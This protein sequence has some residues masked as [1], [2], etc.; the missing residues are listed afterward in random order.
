VFLQ[1]MWGNVAWNTWPEFRDDPVQRVHSGPASMDDFAEGLAALVQH[2]VQRRHYT[3]IRWL[4]IS[5]EPGYDWSWWQQP[6]N[7]SMPL[8]AG[9]AAVRQ[10]L[11]RRGITLPLSG[12]DQTDLPELKPSEI[13]YD[14]FI[15]A[16]DLHSYFARFDWQATNGYPLALAEQR[17][18]AWT[19]WAHAR[20]KPM[21]LSEL[22]SMSFGWNGNHP[23]PSTFEAALKDAELV[24]RG[25]NVGVDG[26]NRWSFINRG[27]LD[28]HWEMIQTWDEG[29]QKL[30]QK[31]TPKPNAY[32]VYGLISRLTPKHS[33]I[34][35]CQRMGGQIDGMNRV[36]AAAL[37]SPHGRL[38]WMILNDAPRAWTAHL[39]IKGMPDRVL[40]RYCVSSADRDT[41]TLRIEPIGQL[42]LRRAD[43]QV[44]TTLPP[45][46]L[47]IFS[48]FKLNHS[49][50]GIT[51]EPCFGQDY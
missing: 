44:D 19:Q 14:P 1:Q 36:F 46:S 39:S 34:L 15:G 31:F 9:L 30:L 25:L 27:D 2:L 32:F 18:G 45:S 47:T 26:F 29:R 7:R 35:N 17:L 24:I 4:C 13:D 33:T 40:H 16:Y 12:P 38:T 51:E 50:R 37:R 8:R 49:D 21:F 43:Q 10:A 48:S 41:P 28:G 42:N 3:C 20:G 6:P 22:G 5:N 23:G 11:D